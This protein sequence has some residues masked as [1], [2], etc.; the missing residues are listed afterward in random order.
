MEL[1]VTA[2]PSWHKIFNVN[3][4]KIPVCPSALCA[5]LRMFLFLDCNGGVRQMGLEILMVYISDD[6]DGTQYL[7]VM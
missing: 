5:E 6:A 2:T 1:C 3:L 7:G 4:V